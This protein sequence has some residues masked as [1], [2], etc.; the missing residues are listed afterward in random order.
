VNFAWSELGIAD[1]PTRIRDLWAHK[2]VSVN[3]GFHSS[4]RPH[5]SVLYSVTL[6]QQ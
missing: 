1:S 3:N 5:A 4:I 2:V 6:E